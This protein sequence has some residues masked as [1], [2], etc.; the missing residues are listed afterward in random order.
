MKNLKHY[1]SVWQ[2]R[3]SKTTKEVARLMGVSTSRTSEMIRWINFKINNGP[4]SR[5]LHSIV[6][7]QFK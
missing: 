1:Y 2:M 6:K 7:K 4:Y 5:E 3:Q